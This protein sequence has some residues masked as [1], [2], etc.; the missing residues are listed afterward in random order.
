MSLYA[1][2]VKDRLGKEIIESDKGFVVYSF[3]KDSV[4]ISDVHISKE[5]RRSGEASKFGDIITDIAKSKGYKTLLGS[6]QPSTKNSTE[7]IQMLL[8]YG[9]KLD[10]STND[11]IILR[12][13]I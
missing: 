8:A 5:Y 2:Y 9:F 1:E 6:V 3:E 7:S 4:Y 10:S 13:E 12:K 11:F